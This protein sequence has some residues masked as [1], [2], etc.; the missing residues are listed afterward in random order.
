MGLWEEG[1]GQTRLQSTALSVCETTYPG[2]AGS[3]TGAGTGCLG[4]EEA[5][6]KA[7]AAL[8]QPGQEQGAGQGRRAFTVLYRILQHV[9]VALATHGP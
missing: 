2:T 9:S 3:K 8:E 7:A 5:R 4:A 6:G 1:R